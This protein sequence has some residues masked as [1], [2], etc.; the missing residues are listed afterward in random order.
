LRSLRGL[1]RITATDWPSLGQRAEK[2][3]TVT[4]IPD[5]DAEFEQALLELTGVLLARR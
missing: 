4:V 3:V 5:A 1:W 2:N